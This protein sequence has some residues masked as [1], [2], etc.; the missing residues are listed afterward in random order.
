MRKHP[1]SEGSY[2]WNWI[3][4]H[5]RS[6]RYDTDLWEPVEANPDQS[7]DQLYNQRDIENLRENVLNSSLV[8]KIRKLATKRELD[9]I[10]LLQKGYNQS[11]VAR[12][13]HLAESTVKELT[14]RI[15]RKAINLVVEKVKWGDIV[16]GRKLV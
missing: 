8:S 15:R 2:Y 11:E 10:K 16:Q 6:S 13:L 4:N 12:K 7:S 14:Q 3:Y 1:A 9:V 5:Q